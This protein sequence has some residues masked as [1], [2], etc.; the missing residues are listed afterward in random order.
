MLAI[1][2][3]LQTCREKHQRIYDSSEAKI[4]QLLDDYTEYG[5]LEQ[6]IPHRR[7]I[8]FRERR[9]GTRSDPPRRCW[10]A[11]Q[12]YQISAKKPQQNI[13][14]GHEFWLHL[15][16]NS[17]EKSATTQQN[18]RDRIKYRSL[19][20]VLGDDALLGRFPSR[21]ESI[22]D[23]GGSPK[24][25][26][27]Q[28]TLSHLRILSFRG[29]SHQTKVFEDGASQRP[30]FQRSHH[31]AASAKVLGARRGRKERRSIL[32]SARG[33]WSMGAAR[34]ER[35]SDLP[36]LATQH[37]LLTDM[38]DLAKH[39]GCVLRVRQPSQASRLRGD[40]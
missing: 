34:L 8:R 13:R 25:Q 22:Y 18:A 24:L 37:Q 5:V 2:T 4:Q 7:A 15:D 6:D 26:L 11:T 14:R 35:G 12:R 16:A 20:I 21:S 32:P 36:V 9:V 38:P 19:E 27:S 33:K 10:G 1:Q 23:Q 29:T 28:K 31:I 39:R 3:H 30:L 40:G 17:L